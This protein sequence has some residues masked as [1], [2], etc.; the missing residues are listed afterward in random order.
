MSYTLVIVSILFSE[1]SSYYGKLA[2]KMCIR[3]N[4]RFERH[5]C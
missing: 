3:W 1:I 5:L 4:G 2:D